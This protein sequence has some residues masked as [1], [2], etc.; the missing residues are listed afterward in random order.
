MPDRA[1]T[2]YLLALASRRWNEILERHFA[3]AGFAEVRASYGA[4]LVPLFE[5]DGLRLGE[6]AR[7]A[8]LS[9]Q[10]VTTMS[11]LLERDRLVSR[12]PDSGDGRATRLFLTE[13]ARGFEPVVESVL[14][15]L[16]QQVAR[17][18][19]PE[20]AS[21]LKRALADLGAL[22]EAIGR[23]GRVDPSADDR[24]AAA[25]GYSSSSSST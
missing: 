12:E 3:D 9:K 11:R 18:L 16:D 8:G 6:L 25:S 2:G 10:T 19:G 13:R 22:G 14:A 1:D 21:L 24:A 5:E 17:I 4:L 7:R 20:S 23:G 15:E